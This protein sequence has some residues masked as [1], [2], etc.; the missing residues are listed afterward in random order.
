MAEAIQSNPP[1]QSLHFIV[2]THTPSTHCIKKITTTGN[3]YK[4]QQISCEKFNTKLWIRVP[5]IKK[6]TVILRLLS[7]KESNPFF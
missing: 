5:K 3:T 6:I 4:E 2:H 7:N 1:I